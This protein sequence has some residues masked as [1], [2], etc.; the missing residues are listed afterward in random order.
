MI[1][2]IRTVFTALGALWLSILIPFMLWLFFPPRWWAKKADSLLQRWSGDHSLSARLLRPI[3]QQLFGGL[4]A[5]EAEKAKKRREEGQL[6]RAAERE[7]AEAARRQEEE[8][9]RRSEQFEIDQAWHRE[10][11]RGYAMETLNSSNDPQ[12]LADAVRELGANSPEV[13]AAMLAR[14]VR[15]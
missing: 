11:R 8:R 9:R 10:R 1:E 5:G 15:R 14:G 4:I 6:R 7:Q 3:V 2:D 13:I 12:K